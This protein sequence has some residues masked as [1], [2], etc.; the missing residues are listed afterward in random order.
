MAWVNMST[1]YHH[2]VN[3]R[4]MITIADTITATIV[5][6]VAPHVKK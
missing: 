5:T 4:N 1:A 3:I 6:I 2:F